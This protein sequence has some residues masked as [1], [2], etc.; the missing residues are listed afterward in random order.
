[1]GCTPITPAIT[2]DTLFPGKVALEFD[3]STIG[4]IKSFQAVHLGTVTLTIKPTDPSISPSPITVNI[5]VAAPTQLGT[6]QK[7]YDTVLIDYANRRGIPP[8]LLK[9]QVQ[10][11]SKFNPQSYRYEPLSSDLKAIS[12]GKNLR[13]KS[14]YSLYR[15]ATSD[16]LPQGTAILPADISPRS[17][18]SIVVN[19][20]RRPILDSDQFVSASAIYNANNSIQNWGKVSPRRAARVAANPS[21]LNF[22]AQTPLASSYGLLQIMYTTAIDSMG[23]EGIDGAQN[24]SNL[25]DTDANLAAGGGSLGR[26]PII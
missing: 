24:P 10:Q 20:V 4:T 3:R 11:E 7:K 16:R 23:W 5:V 21:L 13:I 9:G 22:T 2:G 12:G 25:F 6:T 14:P 8:Q 18:Y 15:L 17:K 19:G 26:V 1:L